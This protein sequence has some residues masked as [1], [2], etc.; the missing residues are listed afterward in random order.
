MKRRTAFRFPAI[1]RRV[2]PSN[3]AW[4][5]RRLK[6]PWA[7]ATPIVNGNSTASNQGTVLRRDAVGRA[8]WGR[9]AP[10][11]IFPSNKSLHHE[12]DS[13]PLGGE[14][15]GRAGGADSIR[16]TGFGE[17]LVLALRN[18]LFPKIGISRGQP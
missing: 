10:I 13:C 16:F 4:S 18:N 14:R 5:Q 17:P 11:Y 15:G 9:V 1:C 2:L 12:E 7:N 3:S 8:Q 6:F